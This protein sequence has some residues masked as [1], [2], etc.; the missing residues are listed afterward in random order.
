[1]GGGRIGGGFFDAGWCSELLAGDSIYALLGEH[2]RIVRDE[3]FAGCDSER[4]GRPSIPPG[5][6]AAV[7]LLA[8]R[9][10][11]SDERAMEAL[12]FD[13]RWE[14]ALDLPID[15]RAFTPRASSA[16]APGSSSTA[17]SGLSSRAR[18]S[19]PPSSA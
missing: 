2:G 19:S 18:S 10:G 8:C 9:E 4:Q 14:V 13:L 17:R 12:R 16:I 7:L 15:T 1:L 3:D 5:L 6:L 11:L